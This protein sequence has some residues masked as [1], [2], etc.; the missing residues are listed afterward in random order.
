VREKIEAKIAELKGYLEEN[1]AKPAK[2][3]GGAFQSVH[4]ALLEHDI[5]L[6]ESLLK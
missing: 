1:A 2:G 6:L 3:L 4:V 5:E